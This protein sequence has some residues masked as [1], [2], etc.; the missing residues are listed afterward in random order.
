M[1]AF[2]QGRLILIVMAPSPCR[3]IYSAAMALPQGLMEDHDMDP[4]DFL[5]YVHDID[6]S[7]VTPD[8]ELDAA[9]ANLPGKK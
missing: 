9:L 3:K 1:T 6:L 8:P 2:I 4:Q 5:S 7:G